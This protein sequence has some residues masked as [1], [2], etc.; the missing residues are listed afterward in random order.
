MFFCLSASIFCSIRF[1]ASSN[2]IVSILNQEFGRTE[3]NIFLY[4]KYGPN[5]HDQVVIS[6]HL[7]FH[8]DFGHSKAFRASC[9]VI[10]SMLLP[11]GIP[12]N[13]GFSSDSVAQIWIMAQY[14]HIFAMTGFHVFGSFHNS[15]AQ[16]VLSA[17]FNVEE[18]PW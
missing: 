13:F 6:S 3:T 18:T 4:F 1:I 11:I 8:N 5:L 2:L 10:V 7:Y 12:A 15:L 16:V 14:L 17:F 9:K